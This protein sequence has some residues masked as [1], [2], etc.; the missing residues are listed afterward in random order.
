[1]KIRIRKNPQ[2]EHPIDS[3]ALLG[4]KVFESFGYCAGVTFHEGFP[5]AL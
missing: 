2:P 5:I 1:M 4:E 3:V